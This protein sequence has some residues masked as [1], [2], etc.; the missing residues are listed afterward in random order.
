MEK[1]SFWKDNILG[2]FIKNT[3][4]AITIVVGLVWATLI[5]ID[6]YTNHGK[7]EKVPD[8][9]GLSMEQAVEMLDRN[10]LK[11]E[12][13]DSVFESLHPLKLKVFSSKEKKKIVIL[14]I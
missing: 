12:I 10:G 7:T 8:L 5:M 3:L 9:K 11:F 13:I 1:K 4:I 14:I 6:F 2:Y